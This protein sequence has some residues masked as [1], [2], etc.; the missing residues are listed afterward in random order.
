MQRTVRIQALTMP[1]VAIGVAL[2]L[3]A[4]VAI[5]IL[6]Q[7][8]RAEGTDELQRTLAWARATLFS[9]G[10]VAFIVALAAFMRGG[11]AAILVGGAVMEAATTPDARASFTLVA[12]GG[13]PDD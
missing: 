11:P 9:A 3:L 8:P 4:L 7:P 1:S 6:L 2:L 13:A 5:S 10:A 12:L